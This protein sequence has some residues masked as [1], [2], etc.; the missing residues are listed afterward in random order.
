MSGITQ[1]TEA[2]QDNAIELL[3]RTSHDASVLF[4]QQKENQGVVSYTYNELKEFFGSDLAAAKVYAQLE[5]DKL[6]AFLHQKRSAI[7]LLFYLLHF[8]FNVQKKGILTKKN[9]GNLK[10]VLQKNLQKKQGI[11]PFQSRQNF[12]NSMLQG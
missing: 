10:P 3:D 4:V 12:I 7:A 6:T 9:I 11:K 5:E 8:Y 2:V 1:S